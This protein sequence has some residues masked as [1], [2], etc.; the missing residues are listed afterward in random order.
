MG[1]EQKNV[2]FL[3]QEATTSSGSGSTGFGSEGIAELMFHEPSYRL[4][5]GLEGLGPSLVFSL[6]SEMT[7]QKSVTIIFECNSKQKFG[8][9][10]EN[11]ISYNML[12]S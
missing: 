4:C 10:S 12:Q 9:N 1:G 8:G 5:L 11:R 7:I 3:G 6:L 2:H